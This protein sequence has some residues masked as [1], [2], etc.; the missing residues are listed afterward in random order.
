LVERLAAGL[1]GL[2]DRPRR[3]ELAWTTGSYRRAF[4]A[5]YGL[6]ADT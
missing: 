2:A 6:A 5:A 4:A 3:P 1:D